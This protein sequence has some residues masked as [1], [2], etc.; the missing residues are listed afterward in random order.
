ML[1]V[2]N[3]ERWW[4]CLSWNETQNRILLR[5]HEFSV[6]WIV[7]CSSEIEMIS[8]RS[9]TVHTSQPKD[10]W[11]TPLLVSTCKYPK[12]S[13]AWRG[14]L[15]KALIYPVTHCSITEQSFIVALVPCYLEAIYFE[16]SKMDLILHHVSFVIYTFTPI[17]LISSYLVIFLS[18]RPQYRNAA[19]W[20]IHVNW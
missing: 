9:G 18:T 16:V 10:D 19:L 20:Y 5:N 15:W 17:V 4:T 13:G 2:R 1:K 3:G 14:G 12:Y 6:K 7:V 8:F 11:F